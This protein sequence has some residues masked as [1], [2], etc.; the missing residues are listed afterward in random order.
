MDGWNVT[1]AVMEFVREEPLEGELRPRIPA[2]SRSVEGVE[3]AERRERR[4]RG[5]NASGENRIYAVPA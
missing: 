1:A 2:A 3:S 5:Q 4:P